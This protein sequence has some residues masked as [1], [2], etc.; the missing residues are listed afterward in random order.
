MGIFEWLALAAGSILLFVTLW[1]WAQNR[2]AEE[3]RRTV[4]TVSWA[5]AL[6]LPY[7]VT[8]FFSYSYHYRLSFAIVPLLIL[9]TAVI[10]AKW[11][12]KLPVTSH[13]SPGKTFGS[14]HIWQPILLVAIVAFSI[15]GII[16]PLYDVNAGWDWLWTDKMPDD[17]A[18]YESGNV[19]LMSVVDGLQTYVDTHDEPLPSDRRPRY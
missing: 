10:L 15:P 17:H 6:A 18:R 11:R 3:G 7:F 14:R 12:E 5:L 9:P 13:Q 16:A 2:W 8:W 4:T 1:H 19:A